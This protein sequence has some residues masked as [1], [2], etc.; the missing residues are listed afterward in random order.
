MD[1]Y[2]LFE[3]VMHYL[4]IGGMICLGHLDGFPMVSVLVCMVT[5]YTRFMVNHDINYQVTMISPGKFVVWTLNFER[6]SN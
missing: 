2:N 6:I 1:L 4:L 3:I 5:Y